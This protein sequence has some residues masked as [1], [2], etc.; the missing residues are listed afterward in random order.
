MIYDEKWGIDVEYIRFLD[1]DEDVVDIVKCF[2]KLP[3][4]RLRELFKNMA[5]A[6]VMIYDEIEL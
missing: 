5:A 6:Q 4:A 3:A 2:K 1:N